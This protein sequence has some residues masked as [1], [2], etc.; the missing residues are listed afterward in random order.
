MAQELQKMNQDIK[1]W[2]ADT[3]KGLKQKFDELD[4]QH[5]KRSPSPS[6]SRDALEN[7]TRKR[8]GLIYKGSF[9]FPRHMVF[10]AKGVGKGVPAGIAG[11]S[12]TQ[13][14]PKDWFNS[15]IDAKID[16]LADTV[17][18]HNANLSADRIKIN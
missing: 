11:T 3:E 15:V 12:A 8:L 9:K 4:I 5:V 16:S 2:F 18:E 13:R 7:I 17:A 1:D 6:A 14:R 10:V